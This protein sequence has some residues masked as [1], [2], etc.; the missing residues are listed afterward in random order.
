MLNKELPVTTHFASFGVQV[1]YV[2]DDIQRADVVAMSQ[3]ISRET[4]VIVKL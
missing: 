1:I 2:T 3:T 4:N